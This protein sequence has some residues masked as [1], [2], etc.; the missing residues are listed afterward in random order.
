MFFAIAAFPIL[1]FT[2]RRSLNTLFF[3]IAADDLHRTLYAWE[4]TQGRLVPSDLWPPLQFWVEALALRFYP[5]VL[6]VPCL[7]NSMASGGT[8]ACLAWLGRTLGLENEGMI[9]SVVLAATIPWFV[10]LSVSGL[11]EPL[12]IFCIALAYGGVAH[13][14]GSGRGWGL[15]TAAL[16]LLAAGMLRFDGWGHSASFSLALAWMWWQA[17]PRPCGWLVAA[18]VPWLFPIVWL[19]RQYARFGDP[20]WFS[21]VTRDAWLASYGALSLETRLTW[22]IKDLWAVA[23]VSVPIALAG[24]WVIRRRRGAVLLSCM[25]CGSFA[26]LMVGTWSHTIT[27]ANPTRLVVVHA[28]LLSP[29]AAL[30]LQKASERKK[31]VAIGSVAFVLALIITRLWVIPAY[32]NGLPDDTAQVGVHFHQLRAQGQ[33]RPGERVMLEV[34]FWDYIMLP[35]LIDSPGDIVYDRAPMG[36]HTF[37]DTAN[38]SVLALAADELRAELERQQVRLVIAYSERAIGHLRPLARETLKTGRFH[39]FVLS[40]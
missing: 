35:V 38:P 2:W 10:W 14:R 33:I 15:W 31:P 28:L 6:T 9:L 24:L 5:H 26:F 1:V 27:Q 23:G 18:L 12:F 25:W 4:V 20:C 11:A 21:K 37:D 36:A 8:L 19:A 32:P 17:S 30:A 34:I 29:L 22:Q 40:D 39:V 16:G 7:V 3:A 13:W